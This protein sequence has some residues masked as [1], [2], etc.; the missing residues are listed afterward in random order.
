MAMAVMNTQ[1]EMTRLRDMIVPSFADT[2]KEQLK[3]LNTV[4][5]EKSSF[6]PLAGRRENLPH[7]SSQNN[8]LARSSKIVDT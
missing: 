1:P 2:A 4:F 7:V 6:A 3:L 8:T 5:I